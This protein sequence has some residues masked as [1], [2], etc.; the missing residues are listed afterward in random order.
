M[1]AR[2][3]AASS[4]QNTTN[5][6]MALTVKATALRFSIRLKPALATRR[7]LAGRAHELLSVDRQQAMASAARPR[8]DGHDPALVADHL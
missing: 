8:P 7:L 4:R 3:R 5:A 6:I 1:E 2:K